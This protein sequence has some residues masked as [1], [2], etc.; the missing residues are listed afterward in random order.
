M[1]RRV[2]HTTN[3]IGSLNYQLRKVIRNRGH[4]PSDDAAAKLLWLVIGNVADK[5]T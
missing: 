4:F 1:L 3:S 5:R 2:I